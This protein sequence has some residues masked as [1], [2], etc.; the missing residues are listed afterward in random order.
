MDAGRFDN[1]NFRYKTK[2]NNYKW[3]YSDKRTRRY[4]QNEF[5]GFRPEHSSYNRYDQTFYH[6]NSWK[7]R[8]LHKYNGNRVYN[9][10]SIQERSTFEWMKQYESMLWD[11]YEDVKL[12]SCRQNESTN[13]NNLRFYS[14]IRNNTKNE[15]TND[16]SNNS[17][18]Q[19]SY[20]IPEEIIVQQ[21][22]LLES[23]KKNT[24]IRCLKIHPQEK[25][26]KL[27]CHICSSRFHYVQDCP[28]RKN[29][30]DSTRLC[31]S[32]NGGN[33]YLNSR[34][35]FSTYRRLVCSNHSNN[36][37][38]NM[39]S[40]VTKNTRIHPCIKKGYE[41][42]ILIIGDKD[43]T[44]TIKDL[45]IECYNCSGTGHII[46][47]NE[48]PFKDVVK[49]AYCALCGNV[50]HNYQLCNRFKAK[51]NE[52]ISGNNSL[53]NKKY[54][55]SNENDESESE[56]ESECECESESENEIEGESESVS[57]GD[58]DEED[59]EDEYDEN[60]EDND[61]DEGNEDNKSEESYKNDDLEDRNYDEEE[62]EIVV[63]E[64]KAIEH[65]S[66]N[67]FRKTTNGSRDYEILANISKKAK[68]KQLEERINLSKSMERDP[69]YSEC[70][71]SVSASSESEIDT[72]HFLN[73]K[74]EAFH[75]KKTK[76][77]FES[78]VNPFHRFK[79]ARNPFKN[80]S[81]FKL[82]G[83]SNSNQN[84]SKIKSAF[85]RNKNIY[86]S[87]KKSRRS[88]S[89]SRR[90]NISVTFISLEGRIS[91]GFFINN[92][93]IEMEVI[94]SEYC[95]KLIFQG[96]EARIYETTLLNKKVVIKH[97]FEKKYRHP[98]LDKS[99]R[100]S[101]ILRESRNLVRC[102]QKGINCP[103]VHFVD[104]DNGIIIMDYIQGTT[105]NDYLSDIMLNS[106]NYDLKLSGNAISKL[107]GQII[108]G[109]LTT[110]NIIISN[111]FNQSEVIF[112]DFGL[113]YSDSLTIEDK[114]VDL[115]VLERSL[116]VTHP[117]I[118]IMDN[119]LSTY[120]KAHPDGKSILNKYK[121]V[122]ARGRKKD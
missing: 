120:C 109:D 89:R 55:H 99:L 46:C 93:L 105:L 70:F 34:L 90:K 91:V 72:N 7:R 57:E 76:S 23:R 62:E 29:S 43:S 9:S 108:H 82:M 18:N 98:Q 40:E 63:D 102:N 118:K 68:T 39:S 122:Q 94:P 30:D 4:N 95:E 77:Q 79:R 54:Y 75:I 10:P 42:S 100:T 67:S 117:N 84:E 35:D 26:K 87:R 51:F 119:I 121:Q 32:C 14:N 103:N 56:S 15:D 13:N 59:Y 113:S 31:E 33:Y 58:E 3:F 96:A 85:V 106:S 110:S 64:D 37:H 60:D 36:K 61:N 45:D 83:N 74:N 66:A 17:D 5:L 20:D 81:L 47:K 21:K 78:K 52:N 24:C 115:Y 73:Q 1:S 44:E 53:G 65:T 22:K 49:K 8:G 114:A 6:N 71:S 27:R 97:R 107:H 25:C 12:D 38:E 19:K 104:V 48:V 16:T 69:N 92:L 101:R 2:T 86:K 111:N 11:T 50:G 80:K 88:A 112:I 28:W 41:E 116:E